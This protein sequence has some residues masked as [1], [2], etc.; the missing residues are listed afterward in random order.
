MTASLNK[1]G[2]AYPLSDL[3]IT[4]LLLGFYS[5]IIA[6]KFYLAIKLNLFGDEAFYWLESQHLAL[7]YSDVPWLMPVLVKLGNYLGGDTTLGV[8]LVFILMGSSLP[9][10]LYIL[11]KPVYGQ[12]IAISS[13]LIISCLPILASLGIAATPDAA[14]ISL[15]LL[16]LI[17]LQRALSSQSVYAW[18]AAGLIAALCFGAHYRFLILL[19]ILALYIVQQSFL[20]ADFRRKLWHQPGIYLAILVALSGLLPNL[21]YN[22][23]HNWAAFGFHFSERHPWTFNSTGLLFFWVQM[24]AVSPGLFLLMVFACCYDYR[25]R[26]TLSQAEYCLLFCGSLYCLFFAVLAPFSDSRSTS[27]HWPAFSYL[28][29]LPIML[30]TIETVAHSKAV[31]RHLM[32]IAIAIGCL[33]S[34]LLF[35]YGLLLVHADAL[36]QE[37]QRKLSYKVS[38]WE[39]LSKQLDQLNDLPDIIVTDNYHTAAQLKFYRPERTLYTIDSAANNWKEKPEKAIRDGRLKQLQIWN[40]DSQALFKQE[41]GKKV[42]LVIQQAKVS[43]PFGEIWHDTICQQFSQLEAVKRFKTVGQRKEFDIYT[44]IVSPN[45]LAPACIFR[46]FAINSSSPNS[47]LILSDKGSQK[48]L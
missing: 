25:Q 40:M 21:V 15:Q 42:T 41:A 18:L 1:S 12:T 38:G 7:A 31:Y 23:E 29:L 9:V 37:I 32:N 39:S 2:A 48:H 28:L 16:L 26:Y 6:L 5:L 14:L 34:T 44:A 35:S 45:T 17:S 24:Q 20:S 27:L 19:A 10:L 8:R 11:V 33:F 22:A 36:P 13:G 46:C 4:L 3:Q 30:K 47:L 43:F